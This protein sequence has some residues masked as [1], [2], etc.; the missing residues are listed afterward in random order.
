MATGPEHYRE[1]EE[2]LDRVKGLN[3]RNADAREEAAILAT[4]ATAHAQLADAAATALSSPDRASTARAA[5]HD[6]HAWR[7]VAGVPLPTDD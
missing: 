6:G 4:L 7:R 2:L 1:A 5:T 3:L